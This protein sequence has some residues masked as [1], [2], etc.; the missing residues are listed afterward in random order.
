MKNVSFAMFADDVTNSTIETTSAGLLLQ[1][2][3][4]VAITDKWSMKHLSVV[5]LNIC[6]HFHAS[7]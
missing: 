1:V 7:A 2:E 6:I 3:F 5:I 4:Y